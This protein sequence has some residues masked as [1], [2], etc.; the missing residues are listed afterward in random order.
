MQAF[1]QVAI[2]ISNGILIIQIIVL[3]FLVSIAAGN[4]S[5]ISGVLLEH[6]QAVPSDRIFSNVFLQ[7]VIFQI[8]YKNIFCI[9]KGIHVVS[10][11]YISG[12]WKNS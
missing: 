4:S 6:Q 5:R 10:Q 7:I 11:C 3:S 8:V 1:I 9:E 12:V 2:Y